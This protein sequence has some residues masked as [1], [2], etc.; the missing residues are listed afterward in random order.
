[1]FRAHSYQITESA[2]KS[3]AEKTTSIFG[4]LT[5]GLSTKLTQ[6]KKSDS[7][8]SLEEKMGSAYENVKVSVLDV[9]GLTKI[10][11]IDCLLESC[12]NSYMYNY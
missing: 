3:T 4:G 9:V 5:S 7:Y 12:Q 2:L 10:I 8:R 1:M 6:M 11:S